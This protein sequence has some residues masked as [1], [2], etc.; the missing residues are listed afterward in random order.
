MGA[1]TDTKNALKAA[2]VAA[3]PAGT[4]VL[5]GVDPSAVDVAMY[6]RFAVLILE[7]MPYEAN[8]TL[9]VTTQWREW[10]WSVYCYAGIGGRDED[11]LDAVAPIL[12]AVA[13]LAG[14]AL[15]SFSKP[16]Q[17]R[18]GAEH[19]PDMWLDGSPVYRVRLAHERKPG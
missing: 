7:R 3:V 18:D 12:E 9:I 8:I 16:L 1:L 15:D 17:V 14:T 11:A 10:Q 2:L 6:P 19:D 4:V 13:G 5:V